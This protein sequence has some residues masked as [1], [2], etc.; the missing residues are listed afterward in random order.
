MNFNVN[1]FLSLAWALEDQ[2][3]LSLHI[4]MVRNRPIIGARRGFQALLSA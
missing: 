1:T 4:Y 3:H 2:V